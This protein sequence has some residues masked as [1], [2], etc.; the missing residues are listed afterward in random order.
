MKKVFAL[1]LA[2]CMV[3]SMAACGNS[4]AAQ[5]ASEADTVA[6]SAVQESAEEAPAEEPAPAEEEAEAPEASAAEEAA[7]AVEEEPVEEAVELLEPL[8]YPVGDGTQTLTY[9]YCYPP[10]V[11]NFL[12]DVSDKEIYRAIDEA[13]GVDIQV[14]GYS[15][16]NASEQFQLMIASGDYTDIIYSFGSNYSGSIEGA[17]EDDIIIDL[18][19]YMEEYAPDYTNYLLS[20]EEVNLAVHTDAGYVPA[21]AGINDEGRSVSGGLIIRTDF[22]DAVGLEMP[23][24]YDGMEEVLKAFRDELDLEI[25]YWSNPSGYVIEMTGGYGVGI[26]FYVDDGVVKY[27]AYEDGFRDYMEMMNRWYDEGLLYHDFASQ[28]STQQFPESDLVNNNKVGIWYNSLNEMSQYTN[29]TS[30]DPNFTISG[31]YVPAQNEGDTT[32]F[33][34]I[35][36]KVQVNSGNFISSTCEDVELAM[37][38]CNYW[39]TDE[40]TLLANYGIEGESWEYDADGN[41]QFTDLIVNNPD[42]AFDIT[43]SVY[44]EF[45]GGGYY[46]LNAKTDGNYTDVQ[47]EARSHWLENAD[48]ICNYPG[49]AALNADESAIYGERIGDIDT[50]LDEAVLKFITGAEE[51]NDENWAAYKEALDSFGLQDCIEVYQSA[52]DRYLAR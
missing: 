24:T 22:L 43:I 36:D 6:E 45:N 32:H 14:V 49:Y 5:S 19:P 31:L 18:A 12:D 41:P 29:E 51:L 44:C 10:F 28:S 37:A 33:S 46:V 50:Y 2:L 9:W 17:I 23:R 26:S 48:T 1:L 15:L 4:A 20:D 13:A 16:V 52:Y 25:P 42:M 3:L 34:T 35:S 39:Y 8:S 27:G 11:P 47:L 38:W 40:G 21:F 30:T 7:S